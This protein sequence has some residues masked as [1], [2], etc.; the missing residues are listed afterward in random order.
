VSATARP[1]A[2]AAVAL[3]VA[4]LGLAG[5][6]DLGGDD[7]DQGVSRRG[8]DA[9]RAGSQPNFVV[10]MT[11][12]QDLASLEDMPRVQ[13]LLAKRGT[14][15]ENA[16]ATLPLC[17]PSRATFLTGQYA[18]NH[19]VM[20]NKPPDGGYQAFR[21]RRQSLG[22]WLQR[23]G[24]RTGWVGK[25]LNGYG[26]DDDASVPPGWSR[27]FGLMGLTDLLMYGYTASVD[28]TARRYGS[29]P[30]DYQTDVLATEA[31]RFLAEAPA[32]DPFF[33]VFAPLA[34][35]D[36]SDAIETGSRDPR[37]APRH[38][39]T[40]D[41]PRLERSPVFDEADVSDKPSNLRE[42]RLTPP[43]L[44]ELR[45]LSL[46]RRES[47]LAVDEAV[48]QIVAELRT[49]G[50]LEDT[51]I[52]YTSDNGYL[53]GEHRLVGG[54]SLPYRGIAG[55][56]LIIRG[57]GFDQGTRERAPVGNVDLAPTIADLAGLEPT[58]EPDGRSLVSLGDDR[59]AADDR[60]LLLEG[61][62]YAA[63]R[64]R[65]FLYVEHESEATELYDLRR[66]PFELESLDSGPAYEKT[67]TR[68]A[69]ALAKLRDCAGSEC[70][71]EVGG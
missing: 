24:Y 66:D 31:L 3:L 1:R 25:Y 34:P 58:R 18:H 16:F 52:I 46:S 26:L 27:W 65:R 9:K 45:R 19:G 53:L 6:C 37:P 8:S 64:T 14:T 60:A 40:I 5:G 33:L 38:L 68:L 10:V 54:K 63:V 35:H 51:V 21:H 48:G 28:G 62:S 39:G 56:P 55:V 12:D 71:I 41:N 20:S 11:D 23:A 50:R 42:P 15:F 44:R 61:R 7:D 32:A 70:V 2:R 29:E 67:R 69:D 22:V 59:T 49:S 17:C 4:L 13:A 30:A 57:P 36:E 43:E 47:L